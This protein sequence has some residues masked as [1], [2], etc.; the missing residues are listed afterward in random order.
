MSPDKPEDARNEQNG[1]TSSVVPSVDD[2]DPV[3]FGYYAML[4]HQQ[5]MLL[6]HVRT[7]I[8]QSA[9][10]HNSH[11]FHD[12][13][14][15]DVGAGSGILSYFAVRAGAQKVYSVE[16]SGM[17]KKLRKVLQRAGGGPNGAP[18][19][20]G[21]LDGKIEV[22]QSKIESPNINIG[23]VDV[24]ISEPIGVLLVHE[25]ML[26]SYLTARDRFLKPGGAMLPN[27]GSIHLSPFTDAALFTETMSKA[28]FWEQT[29][30]YGVNLSVLARDAKVEYFSM[31]VIGHFDPNTL[32]SA[33]SAAHSVDF[34][35]A[36]TADLLDFVVPIDWAMRYTG[37]LEQIHGLAGWFDLSFDPP[38]HLAARAVYMST[39]PSSPNTHWQQVRF[40][41]LEPLAVNAGERVRGWMRCKVNAMRSYTIVA[42]LVRCSSDSAAGEVT[43]PYL[44]EITEALESDDT[45]DAW[46][47]DR[48][49]AS[50]CGRR[51][52]RWFLQ[53]QTYSYSYNA[54]SSVGG[55]S[56]FRP[57]YSS[58]Y[59][60]ATSSEIGVSDLN[61][62]ITLAD[63]AT[64]M[65]Q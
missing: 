29:S 19:I 20:N 61:A 15:L 50:G 26:E 51:R 35:T 22:L 43:D 27:A 64:P 8:Y 45:P 28:R 36:T 25:R 3:Y 6:D 59:N 2:R 44:P 41:L 55:D 48:T 57:E 21:W 5:N 16:A 58:L 34:M 56:S 14:V 42:E 23:R 62:P 40:L 32:M 4:M 63:F 54:A 18:A 49:T 9:I 7:S 30:F 12:A 65:E 39:S 38:P 33:T 31:P 10:V 17:A 46:I 37:L 11:L 24:I 1:A 47:D 13:T 60:A 53:E 52:F